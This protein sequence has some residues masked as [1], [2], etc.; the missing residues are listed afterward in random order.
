MIKETPNRKPPQGGSGTAMRRSKP[1]MRAGE[2]ETEEPVKERFFDVAAEFLVGLCASRRPIVATNGLL[3]D[4][5]K[6]VR[7]E[8]VGD[9]TFRVWITS[10]VFQ[11]GDPERV[12]N[13]FFQTYKG[14]K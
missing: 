6:V 8:V 9:K 1:Y 14:V 12:P 10:S 5:V 2:P 7:V 11:D 3:P 4:D 13:T